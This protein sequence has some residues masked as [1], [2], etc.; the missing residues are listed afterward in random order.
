MNTN[1]N[2]KQQQTPNTMAVS[3]NETNVS[4]VDKWCPCG[5]DSIDSITTANNNNI[6]RTV[7]I[8]IKISMIRRCNEAWKTHVEAHEPTH[9]H[10]RARQTWTFRCVDSPS[11][12]FNLLIG[13]TASGVILDLRRINLYIYIQQEIVNCAASWYVSMHRWAV[14]DIGCRHQQCRRSLFTCTCSPCTVYRQSE[15]D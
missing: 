13:F 14:A 15:L 7:G 11:A 10:A 5:I 8:A 1:N 4:V 2:N 12:K 9:T 3:G 6:G